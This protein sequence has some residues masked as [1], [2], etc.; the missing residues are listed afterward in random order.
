MPSS[1]H[2]TLFLSK[3][4]SDGT[5]SPPRPPIGWTSPDNPSPTRKPSPVGGQCSAG[6]LSFDGQIQHPAKGKFLQPN[7]PSRPDLKYSQKQR[8]TAEAT[9]G[10]TQ[11]TQSH[12]S[13]TAKSEIQG[14]FP[15]T[16]GFRAFAA[17]KAQT[18]PSVNL[19]YQLFASGYNR[20]PGPSNSPKGR[21]A[22][23]A[24][25]PNPFFSCFIKKH[26]E[27]R[28]LQIQPDTIRTA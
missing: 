1:K 2:S 14:A 26:Y 11:R 15:A 8:G 4:L 10:R 6:R 22:A 7:T 24:P 13:H 23:R 18:P 9:S 28:R 5:C 3:L 16:S 17:T 20:H 19:S 27:Y 21:T 25:Q 12:T